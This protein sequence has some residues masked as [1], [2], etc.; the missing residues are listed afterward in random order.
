[1]RIFFL[2]ITL[3]ISV[4]SLSQENNK[5]KPGVKL[6]ENKI[7]S[8]IDSP[9]SILFDF[10]KGMCDENFYVDLVINIKKKLR[11]SNI[12]KVYFSPFELD[13]STKNEYD[14]ICHISKTN[15]NS[16]GNDFV[17]SRKQSFIIIVELENNRTKKIIE[18][19]KI[20]V[21]S[22]YHIGTQNRKL[23]KLIYDL[24]IE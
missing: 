13:E 17:K 5:F 10:R 24:I 1:M 16:W 20:N 7:I 14:L 2:I 6:V 19:A 11:K 15:F 8:K 23:S 18:T 21:K 3:L 9:K 22:Y 12:K 4:Y